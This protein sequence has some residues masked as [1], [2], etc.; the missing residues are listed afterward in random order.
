VPDSIDLRG[1]P[2]TTREPIKPLIVGS[3]E[4]DAER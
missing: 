3:D 4:L 1:L 2:G